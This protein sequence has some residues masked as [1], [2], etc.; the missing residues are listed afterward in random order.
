MYHFKKAG[1]MAELKKHPFD[2]KARD[3]YYWEKLDDLK[4]MEDISL[5]DVLQNWPS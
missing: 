1:K 2:Y 3:K 5:A 4:K